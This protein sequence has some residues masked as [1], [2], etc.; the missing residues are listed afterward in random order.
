[1]KFKD[2]TG[3]I[4]GRLRVLKI[5]GHANNGKII[6]ECKCSCGN[7]VLVKGN[8]LVSGCTKSCGCLA[9]EI[10]PFINRKH[11]LRFHPLYTTWL[12]MKDRC[13]NPNNS[14]YTFY[15]KRD[16][17]VCCLWSDY[18]ISF[19]NWSIH[20]GYKKGLSIERLDNNKGY[21][22]DNCKWIPLSEQSKN[23]RN[24][25][26]LEYNGITGTIADIS[27]ALNIKASTLY[28]RMHHNGTL[29]KKNK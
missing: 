18:F 12:N 2:L 20:N 22:P 24:N 19:Y 5:A 8:S 7:I 29:N 3:Q 9:K 1:M 14:H 15:G 23:R 11:G 27:R 25:Y 21:T 13:N 26:Y 4:F 17:K 16:I 10:K 6:W 28:Y